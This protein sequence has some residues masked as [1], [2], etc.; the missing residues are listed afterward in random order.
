[1]DSD[2][3]HFERHI[4]VSE[5]NAGL[6][7]AFR[8]AFSGNPDHPGRFGLGRRDRAGYLCRTGNPGDLSYRS[9]R[10]VEGVS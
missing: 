5:W 6:N 10:P 9:T 1:M 3:S 4:E 7:R 8:A 2:A